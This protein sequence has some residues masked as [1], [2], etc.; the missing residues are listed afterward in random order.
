M[1]GDEVLRK[2][3]QKGVWRKKSTKAAFR[4]KKQRKSNTPVRAPSLFQKKA[5]GFVGEVNEADGG[6]LTDRE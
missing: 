5:Q 3:K 2:S 6:G 4:A 1:R